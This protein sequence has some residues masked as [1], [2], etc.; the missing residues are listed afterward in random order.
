MA[1]ERLGTGNEGDKKEEGGENDGK[2]KEQ[3]KE[4][5]MSKNPAYNA[6]KAAAYGGH[7][8]AQGVWAASQTVGE[9]MVVHVSFFGGFLNFVF[10]GC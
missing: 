6:T 4:R 2:G 8:F 10:S 9:G 7:V 3:S 5:F 1:L